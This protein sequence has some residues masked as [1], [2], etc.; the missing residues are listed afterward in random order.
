MWSSTKGLGGLRFIEKGSTNAKSF[1]PAGGEVKSA[2]GDGAMKSA[3]TGISI[4]K[5]LR[6]GSCS[7]CTT[8]VLAKGE[9]SINLGVELS[10]VGVA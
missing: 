2:T 7:C 1:L 10:F 5:G 8:E 9:K 6:F 3:M 4:G